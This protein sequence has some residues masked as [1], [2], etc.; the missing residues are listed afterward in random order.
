MKIFIPDAI[1]FNEYNYKNLFYLIEK[2]IIDVYFEKKYEELKNL[3]GNYSRELIKT[4]NISYSESLCE[5]DMDLLVKGEFLNK[6]LPLIYQSDKNI[7]IENLSFNKLKK[8]FYDLYQ[9][10]IAIAK[11]WINFFINNDKL[12]NADLVM[13]FSGCKIYQ[14]V[15]LEIAKKKGIRTLVSE[16]MFTGNE[17][18]FVLNDISP[19]NIPFFKDYFT[20]DDRIYN[21][22]KKINLKNN[23]NIKE[24]GELY[25][26]PKKKK[27]LL[28]LAQVVN[29]YSIIFNNDLQD[30][31]SINAYISIINKFKNS[32]DI[33]LIIKTHPYEKQ[34]NNLRTNLTYMYLQK[35]IQKNNIKNVLLVDNVNIEILFEQI[36]YCVTINSQAGFEACQYG[37]KPII[38]GK[39]FY[40]DYGFTYDFNLKT[41]LELDILKLDCKLSF[42]ESIIYFK[43]VSFLLSYYCISNNDIVNLYL[44]INNIFPNKSSKNLFLTKE[45][46]YKSI[47]NN[48][49][50]VKQYT[51][52]IIPK[53]DKIRDKKRLLKKFKNNP[54]GYMLDSKIFV[55]RC[56]GKIL[57]ELS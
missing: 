10:N 49:S 36:D 44:Q 38:L 31:S 51:E 34:K 1:H 24:N 26:Y 47:L 48:I 45:E 52:N 17:F 37:I 39:C 3:E 19:N 7:T 11:F 21:S 40:S 29:D 16:H 35:Y 41:F 43:Y 14:R 18:F 15:V 27:T 53:T 57:K 25:Y 42:E 56:L 9:N 30:N 12:N 20:Y 22:L 50:N 5:Y 55:L 46:I 33:N 32:L 6:I 4:L 28:I 54:V 8:E 2:G 13:V 23:K